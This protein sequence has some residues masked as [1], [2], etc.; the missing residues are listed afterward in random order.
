VVDG[1]QVDD[2]IE[3]APDPLDFEELLVAQGSALARK[4]E[5]SRFAT[6]LNISYSTGSLT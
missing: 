4:L 3:V 5:L 1:P 2:L 6:W